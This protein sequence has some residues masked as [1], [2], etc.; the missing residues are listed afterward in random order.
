M[1]ELN[2]ID[3]LAQEKADNSVAAMK[4]LENIDP[5]TRNIAISY[6]K[7]VSMEYYLAD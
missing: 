6:V 2:E 4:V 5:E 3:L 7:T 1:Y